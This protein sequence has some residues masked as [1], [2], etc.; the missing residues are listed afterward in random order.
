M[1]KTQGIDHLFLWELKVNV[2]TPPV[3]MGAQFSLW[4]LKVNVEAHV[5]MGARGL[6]HYTSYLPVEYDISVGFPR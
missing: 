5:D 4:E 2:E 3:D 1:R 6:F